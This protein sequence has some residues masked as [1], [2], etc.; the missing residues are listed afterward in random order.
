[1]LNGTEAEMMTMNGMLNKLLLAVAVLGPIFAASTARAESHE[2]INYMRS[3]TESHF[4]VE[5]SLEGEYGKYK[6][7]SPGGMTDQFWKGYGIGTSIGIELMKFVQFT[8]GHT[9]INMRYKEDALESLS[10][11]RLNAGL[12]L[13]FL[14]PIGNLEAGGGVL[15]GRYDYQKQLENASFY[16]S[17]MYYSLGV[18]YFLSSRVSIY[19]EGK[20]NREHMGR[21]GGSAVTTDMDSDA[22]QMGAGFRI[23]L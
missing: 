8:A 23:W 21:D 19:A 3:S 12:R 7:N 16:S 20:M 6:A 15:G 14:S 10:G 1:M 17:G 13:S 11:S 2:Y 22:T 4:F 9:F 5:Q 18:N